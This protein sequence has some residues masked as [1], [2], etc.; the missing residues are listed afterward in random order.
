MR[1]DT[2]DEV[3]KPREAA[4][5]LKL[6]G[7]AVL[8]LAAAGR[9]LM[10]PYSFALEPAELEPLRCDARAHRETWDDM[11][12]LQDSGVYPAAFA[13][14]TSPVLMLHGADDPHPGE[15]IRAGLAPFVSRLECVELERCGHYPWLERHAR[16]RFAQELLSWL[17]RAFAVAR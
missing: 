5:L 1:I 12:R 13:A 11:V 7:K 2:T 4:H 6:T 15:R 10:A 16:T 9:L 14:I 3:L 8:H 17:E